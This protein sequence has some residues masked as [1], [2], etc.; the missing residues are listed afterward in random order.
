MS[1]N[2]INEELTLWL[3]DHAAKAQEYIEQITGENTSVAM[4][5]VLP[6]HGVMLVGDPLACMMAEQSLLGEATAP[7]G[8]TREVYFHTPE[9]AND[10]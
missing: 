9:G 6:V 10:G 4:F 5:A 3:R 1:N 7:E 8:T 2:P